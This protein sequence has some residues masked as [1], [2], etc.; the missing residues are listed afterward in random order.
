MDERG[1][2]NFIK[3]DRRLLDHKIINEPL[4][5]QLFIYCLLRAEWISKTDK[6]V[7]VPR[8]SFITTIGDLADRF[9]CTY[10]IMKYRLNRL[11]K[12]E[13]GCL[14]RSKVGKRLMITVINYNKWQ[15]NVSMSVPMSVPENGFLPIKEKEYKNKKKG[16]EA[17]KWET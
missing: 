6:G 12:I 11:S 8:G 7:Y 3:L 5:L 2:Q 14:S 17:T 16:D 4:L 9:G 1:S 13:Y 15:G 10:R